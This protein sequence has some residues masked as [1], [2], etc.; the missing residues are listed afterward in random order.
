MFFQKSFFF[1]KL[2]FLIILNEILSEAK[3]QDSLWL[4]FFK[5]K[6]EWILTKMMTFNFGS[7]YTKLL[8]W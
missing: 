8:S 7:E 3:F 4:C 1:C 5:N 2:K 6:M